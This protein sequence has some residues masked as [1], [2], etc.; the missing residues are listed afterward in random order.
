MKSLAQLSDL[1]LKHLYG[2]WLDVMGSLPNDPR[3]WEERIVSIHEE[4][5]SR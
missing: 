1:E 3:V 5:A 4:L 2:Y